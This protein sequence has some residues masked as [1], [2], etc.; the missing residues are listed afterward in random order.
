[1]KDVPSRLPVL[2]FLM[3]ICLMALALPLR[4]GAQADPPVFPRPPEIQPLVA[5]WVDIFSKYGRD[6]TVLHDGD[7]PR[8]RYE[9]LVT[10]GM[11]EAERRDVVRKR[12]DHYVK[13]LEGL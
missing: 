12:K 1:M 13:I 6:E 9:T 2:T 11:S 4:A 5:F 7:D 10:R 3:A 8:I